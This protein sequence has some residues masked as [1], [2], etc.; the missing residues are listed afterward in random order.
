MIW[1]TLALLSIAYYL[2]Q[3]K[4]KLDVFIKMQGKF[5]DWYIYR[6]TEGDKKCP[7]CADNGVPGGCMWCGKNKK[8]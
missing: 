2:W 7:N 1:I 8:N 3:I 5:M 6:Q 4:E